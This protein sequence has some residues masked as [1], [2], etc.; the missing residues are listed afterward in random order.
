MRP[1]LFNFMGSLTSPARKRLKQLLMTSTARQ[2]HGSRSAKQQLRHHPAIQSLNI[3]IQTLSDLPSDVPHS[4][5]EAGDD[6]QAGKQLVPDGDQRAEWYAFVHVISKWQEDMKGYVSPALYRD[7]L[8]KSKL[9]LCPVGHN[10][11]AYRIYEAAMSGS[12]PVVFLAEGYLNSTQS[13]T[14]AGVAGCRDA[15]APFL[16]DGAPFIYLER[17]EDLLELIERVKANEG[18]WVEEQSR[19]VLHWVRQFMTRFASGF[20]Q[21]LGEQHHHRIHELG[22]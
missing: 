2:T 4:K 16:E 18:G 17:Y 20:E 21:R 10:P 1:Y 19:A 11:E 3:S 6:K 5:D 15:Y 22:Q 7:L 13:G 9:T 14:R 12:I 8:L